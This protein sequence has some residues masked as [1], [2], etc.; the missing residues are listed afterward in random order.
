MKLTKAQTKELEKLIITLSDLNGVSGA[1]TE[2]SDFIKDY[3]QNTSFEIS[4]DNLG[5]IIV[6]KPA[7]NPDAKRVMLACHIDEVG[8]RVS[9][10]NKDG[11]L[12]FRNFGRAWEHILLGQSVNVHANG[13]IYRGI[14]GSKPPHLLTLEEE[15]E[16]IPLEKLFI[17]LGLNSKAEVN[18]L[19][20]REGSVITFASKAFKMSGSDTIAGKALDNRVSVAIGMLLM[21]ILE[22]KDLA[23][24]L[25]FVGTVQEEVGLRGAATSAY[26]INPDI[27]LVLD[28]TVCNEINPD[29]TNHSKMGSGVGIALF[30]RVSIADEK[31]FQQFQNL[32]KTN[33]IPYTIDFIKNGGTDAG[34]ILLS[35]DGAKAIT[36]S[37]PTRYFHSQT[38][39]LSLDDA[40]Q[41]LLLTQ[42]FLEQTK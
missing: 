17:D 28:V 38:A 29:R 1:E 33:D 26:K 20:I 6:R 15:K 35:R 3:F 10:I 22:K 39:L 41:T 2:V 7:K 16:I 5:S 13:E 34:E 8:F 25:Y 18:Q 30:N 42:A 9:D 12:S 19:G 21:K 23:Y 32:A 36:L 31:L 4:Y 40:T 37:V 27:G 24:D 14:I 11:F